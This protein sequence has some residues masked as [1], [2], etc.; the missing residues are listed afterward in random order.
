MDQEELIRGHF[1][2]LLNE[3]QEQEYVSLYASDE[4]FRVQA[5]L[6]EIE[7]LGI[8]TSGRK[9]LNNRFNAWEEEAKLTP[10]PMGSKSYLQYGIAASVVII[11]GFGLF[12]LQS[13]NTPGFQD[14][15]EPYPNFEYT[16]TR[17]D[18]QPS[19]TK[20]LGYKAYDNGQYK[21]A[22]VYFNQHLEND[23]DDYATVLFRGVC[24]METDNFS[25]ANKDFASVYNNH[26]TYKNAGYWYAALASLALDDNEEAKVFLRQIKEDPEFGK[27]ATELLE[28][29]GN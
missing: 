8:R 6:M 22:L 14:Y 18:N 16:T 20:S 12:L 10:K 25:A 21:D 24:L 2:R 11:L 1:N 17:A 4:A 3:R 28:K 5:D 29:L 13:G 27:E 9:D 7:I 19:S 23:G 15:Y 26:A